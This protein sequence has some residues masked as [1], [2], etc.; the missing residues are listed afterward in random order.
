MN[1]WNKKQKNIKKI[2]FIGFFILLFVIVLL[3]IFYFNNYNTDFKNILNKKTIYNYIYINNVDV[4][5]KTKEQAINL[6][7]QSID[8]KK[9][10]LFYN[11]KKYV[12][13]KKDF[14]IVYDFEM[15]V[16]NAFNI[17]RVGNL[18]QRYNE[19]KNLKNSPT[20]VIAEKKYNKELIKQKLKQIEK[21]IFVSPINASV[22]KNPED[23][24]FTIIEGKNGIKMNF[25]QTFN[26][27]IELLEH[28]DSGNIYI[29]TEEIEP[30]F[31][32]DDLINVK[33]KIGVYSTDF[34][35]ND[36]S[37]NRIKNMKLAS[38]KINGTVVYPN[39]TFFTNKK[40]G[41]IDKEHGF[42]LA[43]TIVN[44]KLEQSYGGGV[45]QIATTLYNAVL[46]AELEI[47]QRSNH[48]LKVGYAAYGFDATLAGDYIDFAFKNN[49][50]YPIYIES[51]LTKNNKVVCNIY[52]FETRPK[53]RTIKFTKELID[54]IEPDSPII[55][56][57]NDLPKG[58]KDV[59]VSE[60]KGYKFKIYKL[61]YENGKLKDKIFINDSYY[62]PRTAE[63]LIGTR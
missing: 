49:L 56:Y 46:N 35:L 28:F 37:E 2:S 44:G 12:F 7:N 22:K 15:A 23:T 10:N 19:I 21:E 20:K 3:F 47:V 17:G 18:K 31:K 50:D 38:S 13:D 58:V 8:N 5:G 9:I 34:I 42:E 54:E 27:V 1:V 53:E 52:G 29:T 48:S 60:Q 59:K 26:D 14:E 57:T 45:C 55:T 40:I 43:P 16:E 39:E 11:D 6:L 63:I 33:D 24:S 51:F 32:E 36:E 41:K 62:K 61:I 4:S 30:E 25:E